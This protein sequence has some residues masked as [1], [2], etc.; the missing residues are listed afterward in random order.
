MSYLVSSQLD[1]V[2]STNYQSVA[3]AWSHI[4]NDKHIDAKSEA[5]GNHGEAVD[6]LTWKRDYIMNLSSIVRTGKL[7]LNMDGQAALR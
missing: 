6:T 5:F 3:W 4:L 1:L 7:L 2:K